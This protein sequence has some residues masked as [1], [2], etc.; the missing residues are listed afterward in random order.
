[1][2]SP[3]SIQQV[4]QRSDI[5]EVIGQFIRLKKRGINYIGNCPF[6]NEKTPSFNVNPSK[7]IFKCFGCGKGGDVVSFVEEYEKFTFYETI[8]WLANFYQIELEESEVSETYKQ[9]AQIE[10]SLR[11]VNDFAAKYFESIL[12]NHDMGQIIGLSYFKEREFSDLTIRN[13]RLGYSL[14]EWDAFY[15]HAIAQGY[16]KEILEKAGLVKLR[17]NGQLYDTYRGRVIF[18]IQSPTGK[19]LGFGARILKTDGKQPKYINTQENE[20]YIK[21]KV[22][23]GLFQSRQSISKLDEC[24]LVEGYTDVISL[25]QAGVT[26]VVASSGT[27]LTEGQL[28]LISN[29]TK[30]LTIIYDGDAAGIKAALRGLDK[31]LSESFNV[32]LVLLPEGEDPDSYIKKIGEKNFRAFILEH[33]QDII[34]FKLNVGLKEVGNDPV[35]K[36]QLVN[37][38]AETIS[39]INKLEDFALRSYFTQSSAQKLGVDEQGLINL[40]NKFIRDQ[41]KNQ[42]RQHDIA[43]TKNNN[44]SKDDISDVP[45]FYYDE[46]GAPIVIEK[47]SPPEIIDQKKHPIDWALLRIL[48]E[49]GSKAYKNEGSVATTIF[50]TIDE[51]L[52]EDKLAHEIFMMAFTEMEHSGKMPPLSFFVNH[53]NKVIREQ[54]AILLNEEYVPSSGWKDIVRIEVPYGEAIYENELDSIFTYFELKLI[55]RTIAENLKLMEHEKNDD[56]L[57]HCMMVH[58][59]LKAQEKELQKFVILK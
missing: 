8:R 11:I 17:D 40:V 43:T 32:Q 19:V 6:H 3:A 27:S 4:I 10:E 21:N 23:Y 39:K 24:L 36:S 58:Q 59:Q 47:A 20:V 9:Q 55:R 5:V 53:P 12:W 34:S 35:K 45:E 52:I 26:N 38:I 42:Q 13:F 56:K 16:T 22:L 41:V 50:N 14:D 15:A 28:K 2:I 7:G 54:V 1:M 33:K 30:N 46:F 31:A 25:H 48:I 51:E 37:D 18:P 57:M 44:N 49:F 29:L